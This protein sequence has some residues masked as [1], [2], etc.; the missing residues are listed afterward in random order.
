MHID[1]LPANGERMV[2]E[3]WGD[4]LAATGTPSQSRVW[5]SSTRSGA[6]PGSWAGT[7]TLPS[8][9]KLAETGWREGEQAIK[10]L[11]QR[12]EVRML[13]RIVREDWNYDTEGAMFDVSRYLGGE[14]EHWVRPEE[15]DLAIN[16]HKHVRIV[17]N[18]CASCS[19][20]TEVMAAR[21]AAAAALIE[22]LEYAGHRVELWVTMAVAVAAQY[23]MG[24]VKASVAVKV[25]AYDQHLDLARVAYAT[26]HASML[27]RLG[28][29]GWEHLSVPV[30]KA[31]G[32]YYGYPT[33]DN[34][35]FDDALLI[36]KALLGEVQWESPEAAETWV[37]AKL[38]EQGVV[39]RDEE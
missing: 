14:P 29:S 19:V 39:I 10:R 34:M 1:K 2:C 17:Y 33:D 12:L 4:F 31:I 7:A 3:S 16:A 8:A 25:K 20:S 5:Q 37:L 28:F 15:A 38:A 13:N 36:S 35:G 27:R 24:P 23:G 22:L 32:S 30:Q 21:G 18:A 11:T 9:V 26:G 6:A